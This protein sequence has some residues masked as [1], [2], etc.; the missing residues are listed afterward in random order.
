MTGKDCT[1]G[2]HEDC[3]PCKCLCHRDCICKVEDRKSG[4]SQRDW[5]KRCMCQAHWT[6]TEYYQ[7]KLGLEGVILTDELLDLVTLMPDSQTQQILD[8]IVSLRISRHKTKQK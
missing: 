5:L 7:V 1:E 3:T 6:Q 4:E 8:Y 2:F